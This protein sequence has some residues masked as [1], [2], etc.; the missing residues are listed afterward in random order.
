[1]VNIESMTVFNMSDRIGFVRHASEYWLLAK[2]IADRLFSFHSKEPGNSIG[3]RRGD[4]STGSTGP[5][6]ILPKYDQTSMQ[7]VNDLISNFQK[8]QLD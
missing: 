6:F 5:E 7:Q 1:M 8:V 3:V 4:D 2:V